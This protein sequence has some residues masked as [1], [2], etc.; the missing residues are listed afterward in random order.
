MLLRNKIIPLTI[1][2]LDNANVYSLS[3]KVPLLSTKQNYITSQELAFYQGSF[4]NFPKYL[5]DSLACIM[6]E[7]HICDTFVE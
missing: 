4:S 7:W 6:N 1:Q 5:K 2:P 3:M